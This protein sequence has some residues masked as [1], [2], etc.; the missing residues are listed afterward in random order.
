MQ[1]L[2]IV[3]KAAALT[4]TIAF[5]TACG[6][7][8]SLSYPSGKTLEITRGVWDSYQNY[9]A[10]QGGVR[11][12]G[13]FLVVM[14]GDTGVGSRWSYCPPSADYCTS[15]GLNVANQMCVEEHF[16]CVLFARGPNI[17][18]PYKLID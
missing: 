5:L 13:V 11:K 4:A 16:K 1:F 12:D 3:K 2:H 6:T 17:V 14:E 10:K 15:G 8:A 9:L 18:L 7:P